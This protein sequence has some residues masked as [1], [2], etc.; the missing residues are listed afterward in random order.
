MPLRLPRGI[1][2]FLAIAYGL[3]W[4][5][6][7][8]LAARGWNPGDHDALFFFLFA[9]FGPAVAAL[10]MRLSVTGEGFADAGLRPRLLRGWRFYLAAWLMP[11]PV[12]VLVLWLGQQ[13]GLAEPDWSLASGL[14]RLAAKRPDSAAMVGGAGGQALLGMAVSSLFG[15]AVLFGEEFGWRGW[16]QRRIAPGRPLLAAVLTGALWS[17][18]HL[19]LNLRGYNFPGH[20][21][22]GQIVF[23]LSLVSLS[24]I[25]AWLQGRAGS[26]WAACLAHSATNTMGASI[27]LLALGGE[28]SVSVAYLGWLGLLPLGGLALFLVRTGRLDAA[29]RETP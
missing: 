17:F 10:I 4:T 3:S 20:P 2:P 19:P 21:V 6:W 15:A 1:L 23:T 25:F 16:L 9:S 18:W 26:I 28:P 12:A 5:V 11:L 14:V 8:V 7:E 24:I 22:E 27:V 29:A 13:L